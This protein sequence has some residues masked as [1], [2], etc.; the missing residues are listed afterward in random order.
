MKTI[1]RWGGYTA[2][3][4]VL[5]IAIASAALYWRL[6]SAL[7]QVEG[8]LSLPNL[9]EE[10]NIARDTD[11]ITHIFAN[12]R[13]DMFYA[14][15]VVHAQERMFQ[16]DMSRRYGS[17]RLAE[18]VG[19]RA[20]RSDARMR[21]LG[22]RRA[23]EGSLPYFNATEHKVLEAY[24]QGVN[25]VITAKNYVPPAEYLFL[26]TKPEPWSV[27]DTL[28]VFKVMAFNLSGDGL[29]EPDEQRLLGILGAER[30]TQFLPPYPEDGPV[31][32]RS[33]D[34]SSVF[35]KP[36]QPAQDASQTLGAPMGEKVKGSNNWVV[37]GSLSTSGMPL[38]ANDPHLSLSAPGVWYY[39][40]LNAP[41]A[42]VLGVTLPGTPFVTLGR[43]KDI[44]WGFTNTGPDTSDIKIIKG[45]NL[46]TITETI[47]VR[48]EEDVSLSIQFDGEN[49]VLD[50]RW[51]SIK[52]LIK[53]GESAVLLS[54]LDDEDDTTATIGLSNID[55]RTFEEMSRHL[56]SF[57]MPQQNIVFADINGNIGFIAPARVPIR[58]A[59]G[60]W[61][62]EIPF[63]G[64]P[65]AFNPGQHYVATANNK[66]VPDSYPYH[67]TNQWYGYHRAQR[68]VDNIEATPKHDIQSFKAMQMD[69]V[70]ALARNA[71]PL[72][73]AAQP[74]TEK[75]QALRDIA[76]KWDGN[77]APGRPEGLIYSAWLRAFSRLVYADDLGKDFRRFWSSRR[78]FMDGVIRGA[79]A[80]W[81]DNIN[82]DALETCQTLAGQAF[83]EAAIFLAKNHSG[84]PEQWRW[85]DVH[86]A[87]FAHPLFG[88]V[89]VLKNF[90]SVRVP[91]GGDGST[92]NV[93]HVSYRSG[94]FD[95]RWGVSM[96][97]IYDLSDMN[98]SQ[99]MSAPG[100][101]G[102]VLS[103]HY[104]D[105]AQR[106]ADGEYIQIRDDWTPDS[107]PPD[108]KI[109]T[110]TPQ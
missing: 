31:A 79:F 11:G 109:L 61:V 110:L 6:H 29:D 77:L 106:W 51:F 45:K 72:F 87:V 26:R 30:L 101:S 108:T 69:T 12:N 89:P 34:M 32:L 44:A 105:M 68:I 5:V 62:G 64:L 46:T 94:N 98:A 78:A 54:T 84:P 88:E 20:V 19:K 83:D 76:A 40:R 67:I 18:L 37:D 59:E 71:L 24:A 80:N 81:C 92:P 14:L 86:Q 60:N 103:P 3:G 25:A 7:P 53:E 96:R 104:R 95:A 97:A 10:V 8:E 55:A 52:R 15:G 100:Q 39:A 74:Q 90:F 22:L 93:A 27:F 1:F 48:G 28:T 66:I 70:S 43:N 17:G 13:P 50:P 56:K 85:G 35:P 47:K 107:P 73:A 82:T 58:D 4:L 2:I 23:A 9:K 99:Y 33:E 42:M 75:G 57:K 91:V 63:E 38:L 41:D 16:M 102:H 49:V 36:E 65:R 21:T